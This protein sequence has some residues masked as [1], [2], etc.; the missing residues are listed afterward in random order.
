MRI[1]LFGGTFNPVHIGH[2][3]A[4][5]EIHEGF[6]LDSCYLIPS[7]IP[8]HKSRE[9]V[10]AAGHR[11]EMV[12]LAASHTPG[13]NVSDIEIKRSGPSYTIDTVHYF[14]SVLPDAGPLFFIVGLDAFLEIDT[15]K[16][17]MDLFREISFIV[18]TRPG[19]GV[20]GQQAGRSL[21]QSVLKDKVSDAYRY[22]EIRSAFIHPDLC[23]VTGFEVSSLDISSTRIRELVG[24]GKSIQ[25][26]VPETVEAYIK[27]KGLYK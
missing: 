5:L 19:S 26:L 10:A 20:E 18:M 3:R 8:P 2:L 22:D 24:T 9:G 25:F 4:A 16:S 21:L 1:G 23:P 7:A 6:A 14:K 27:A 15:W 13:F 11:L 17:Y 12:R